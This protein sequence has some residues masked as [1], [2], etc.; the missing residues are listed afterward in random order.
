MPE[1]RVN[2]IGKLISGSTGAVSVRI[3]PLNHKIRNDAMKGQPIIKANTF[4]PVGIPGAFGQTD[5]IRDRQGRL[6][7]FQPDQDIT[8]RSN[9]LCVKPVCELQLFTGN[10]LCC[11]KDKKQ[12]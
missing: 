3:T 10:A 2:L 5:K 11:S 6:L 1:R 12:E 8:L 4:T 7:I 9:H